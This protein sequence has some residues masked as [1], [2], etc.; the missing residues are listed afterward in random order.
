[1]QAFSYSNS[2]LRSISEGH[3]FVPSAWLPGKVGSA[4]VATGPRFPTSNNC[5]EGPALVD[6][7][8]GRAG[9]SFFATRLQDNG[10]QA[11]ATAG[12]GP[13]S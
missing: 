12:P 5:K 13:W 4:R 8:G 9:P 1:M 6:V 2:A 7:E 10:L 3:G 11:L